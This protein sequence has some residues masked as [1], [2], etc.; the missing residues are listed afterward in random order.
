MIVGVALVP[1]PPIILEEIGRGEERKA[2]ETLRGME[3]VKKKI[4]G[5]E[6]DLIIWR[7]PRN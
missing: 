3:A 2:K 1:H 7:L 4:R 5:S 6:P